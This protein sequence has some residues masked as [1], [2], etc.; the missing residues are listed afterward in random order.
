MMYKS[1]LIPLGDRKITRM[2]TKGLQRYCIYLP[3]NLNYL[4][5]E[6]YGGGRKVRVYIEVAVSDERGD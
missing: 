2:T 5:R 1:T 6:L 4:W 3:T